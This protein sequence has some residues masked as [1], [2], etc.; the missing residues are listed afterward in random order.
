MGTKLDLIRALLKKLTSITGDHWAYD[1]AY[2][3]ICAAQD[4]G[5]I[6]LHY[7]V[8]TRLSDD[9]AAYAQHVIGDAELAKA[10]RIRKTSAKTNL[11]QHVNRY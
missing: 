11:N 3:A 8:D 2:N 4:D 9:I 7:I 6:Y 5:K 1:E 10:R